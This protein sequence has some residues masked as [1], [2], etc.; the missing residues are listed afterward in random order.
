MV[1][2][3]DLRW[4]SE[5]TFAAVTAISKHFR[6]TASLALTSA[7]HAL[8]PNG[9][10]LV[11]KVFPA[12]TRVVLD[13]PDQCKAEEDWGT[14]FLDLIPKHCS[15]LLELH[16]GCC[17]VTDMVLAQLARKYASIVKLTFQT[18]E[19]AC[20]TDTGLEKLAT[21]RHLTELGIFTDVPDAGD[22]TF[23][24]SSLEKILRSCP[25]LHPE[26]LECA[27]KGDVFAAAVVDTHPTITELS[28]H[29][30]ADVGLVKVAQGCPNLATVNLL[31][32]ELITDAGLGTLAVGCPNLTTV[33]LSGSFVTDAGLGKLAECC[34]NLATLDLARN[35]KVTDIG[36]GKLAVGC[37]ILATLRVCGCSRITDAG[38]R[39]LVAGCPNLDALHLI[40]RHTYT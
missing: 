25:K 24:E 3:L 32:C 36:L 19:S 33:N 2:N 31:N 6:Q 20:V 28:L 27:R 17:N 29:A 14:A 11:L 16:L 13:V 1:V 15:A 18:G 4:A 23:T 5:V 34:P 26:K 30:V 7:E 21:C 37:P 40:N 8:S 35:Q 38:L 39:V 12:L 22:V 9:F 10:G